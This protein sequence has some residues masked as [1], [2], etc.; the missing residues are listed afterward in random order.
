MI[1]TYN[2]DCGEHILPLKH[3]QFLFLFVQMYYRSSIW[4]MLMTEI[5]SSWL[6]PHSAVHFICDTIEISR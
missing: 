1:Q 2:M 3:K 5:Y 6:I 4:A